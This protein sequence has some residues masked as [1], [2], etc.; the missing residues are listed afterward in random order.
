M[1]ALNQNSNIKEIT[2]VTNKKHGKSKVDFEERYLSILPRNIEHNQIEFFDEGFKKF[3][4]TIG[5]KIV[6]KVYS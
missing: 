5:E 6:Q 3:K 1:S 4:E 2:V